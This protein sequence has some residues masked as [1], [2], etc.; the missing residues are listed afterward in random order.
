MGSET[1]RS[2]EHAKQVRDFYYHLITYL[3]AR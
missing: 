1:D 2:G 3:S